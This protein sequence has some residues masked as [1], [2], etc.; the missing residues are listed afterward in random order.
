MCF[1][2]ACISNQFLYI[3]V[4]EHPF[5]LRFADGTVIAAIRCKVDTV[6]VSEGY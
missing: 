4:C 3:L 1:E 6:A 2:N 5:I